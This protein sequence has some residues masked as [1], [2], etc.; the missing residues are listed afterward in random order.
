ML[1]DVVPRLEEGGTRRV[2]DFMTAHSTGSLRSMR[3]RR[4]RTRQPSQGPSGELR[5]RAD[6]RL[7]WDWDPV[8]LRVEHDAAWARQRQ[9]R[10]AAAATAAFSR[11]VSAA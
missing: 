11:P 7:L 8:L 2:P 4:R 10:L 6:G 1:V 3:W 9:V 5:V